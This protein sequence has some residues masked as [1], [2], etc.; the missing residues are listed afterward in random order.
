MRL[1]QRLEHRLRHPGWFGTGVGEG[2]AGKH[3]SRLDGR[4]RVPECLSKAHE[5]VCACAW[6]PMLKNP[7]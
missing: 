5:R 6:A 2:N 1:D 3:L 7:G 4:A